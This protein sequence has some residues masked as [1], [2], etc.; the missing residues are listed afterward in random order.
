LKHEME[1]PPNRI[2]SSRPGLGVFA[3][4]VVPEFLRLA[5]SPLPL[6]PT[7]AW[8]FLA[9]AQTS[10]SP[11]NPPGT[12]EFVY[13]DNHNFVDILE[14]S[15]ERL[16]WYFTEATAGTGEAPQLRASLKEAPPRAANVDDGNVL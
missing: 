2:A 14:L 12:W 13:D 16:R 11:S 4:V 1:V 9:S 3:E 15:Y 8:K 6:P 7:I 10:T 5:R